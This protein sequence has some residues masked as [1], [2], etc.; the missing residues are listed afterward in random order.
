MNNRIESARSEGMN[1][2][3][4]RPVRDQWLSQSGTENQ[5]QLCSRKS[6]S[7]LRGSHLEGYNEDYEEVPRKRLFGGEFYQT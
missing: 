3:Y 2:T 4:D 5:S 7:D 1:F 6:P